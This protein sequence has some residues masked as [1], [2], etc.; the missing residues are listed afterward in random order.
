MRPLPH[1]PEKQ[2]RWRDIQSRWGQGG[3]SLI[4]PEDIVWL[5][6]KVAEVENQNQY[7]DYRYPWL[8]KTCISLQKKVERLNALLDKQRARSPSKEKE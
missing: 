2:D 3:I 5:I 8:R 1:L 4:T 7:P 6:S